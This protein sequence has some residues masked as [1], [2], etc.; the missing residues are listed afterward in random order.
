[1][2]KYKNFIE[3]LN[4][5]KDNYSRQKEQVEIVLLVIRE[6]ISKLENIANN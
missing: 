2:E 6:E 1:M 3:T 4:V 5:N